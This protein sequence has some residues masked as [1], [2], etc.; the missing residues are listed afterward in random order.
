MAQQNVTITNSLANVIQVIQLGRKSGVLTV[1]R[2]AGMTFEEGVITFVN[3][4]AVDA[5]AEVA[6]GQDALRWL[7][8]WGTCRYEFIPTPTSKMPFIPASV[9]I[10]AFDRRMADTGTH[11]RIPTSPL[12]ESAARRQASNGRMPA[13]SLMPA[14]VVPHPAKPLEESLRRVEQLGFSRQHRRL[15][16]L[17]DGQRNITE[18]VR[19]IGYTQYEVRKLLLDLEQAGIIQL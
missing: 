10:P 8:S 12:R 5:L 18:M 16:L 14:S 6:N 3:G 4:Q 15:L 2:G 9:S 1:E 13:I 17:V 7:G 19:L 11:P